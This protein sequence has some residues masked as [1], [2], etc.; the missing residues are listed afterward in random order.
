MSITQVG[1]KEGRKEEGVSH[2]RRTGVSVPN[3]MTTVR[4]SPGTMSMGFLLSAGTTDLK[5]PL[6]WKL[7]HR[8]KSR[9]YGGL[10]AISEH[11]Y[12]QKTFQLFTFCRTTSG[13]A[14]IS[15]F[16]VMSCI[17]EGLRKQTFVQGR[18]ENVKKV[19]ISTL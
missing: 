10:C 16:V 3:S 13:E 1:R 7:G 15:I 11:F 4:M 12:C 5:K 8:G 18:G 17:V 9:N 14:A 6:R 19:C 2:T